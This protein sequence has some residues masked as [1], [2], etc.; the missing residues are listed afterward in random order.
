MRKFKNYAI[1]YDSDHTYN[2]DDLEVDLDI[3]GIFRNIDSAVIITDNPIMLSENMYDYYSVEKIK[4]SIT[5]SLNHIVNLTSRHKFR[6]SYFGLN[7]FRGS[8]CDNVNL[9]QDIT[10]VNDVSDITNLKPNEIKICDNLPIGYIQSCIDNNM[11]LILLQK[12]EL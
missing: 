10:I 1:Y 4:A 11:T 2:E 7:N 6:S 5:L 8:N 12:G 9:G 3:M